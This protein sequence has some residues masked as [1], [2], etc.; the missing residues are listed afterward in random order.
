VYGVAMKTVAIIPAAGAGKRMESGVSK[1]Y[2]EL[3]G[4]PILVRTLGIFEKTDTDA[5]LKANKAANVPVQ[6][7]GHHANRTGEDRMEMTRA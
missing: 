2:L 6:R 3:E 4:V 7:E 1:Q 5:R